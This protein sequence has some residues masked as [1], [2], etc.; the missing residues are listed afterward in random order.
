VQN[1]LKQMLNLPKHQ[2]LD[3]HAQNTAIHHL[4][5]QVSNRA[6]I[7]LQIKGRGESNINVWFPLM[8]SYK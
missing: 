5:M 6:A 8:N 3:T 2:T 7:A 4:R 1:N